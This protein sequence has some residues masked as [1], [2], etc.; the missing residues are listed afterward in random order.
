M[1]KNNCFGYPEVK[2]QLNW[3]PQATQWHATTIYF[4]FY[5]ADNG[6][7]EIKTCC[8]YIITIQNFTFESS[9][10]KMTVPTGIIPSNSKHM[11][12]T[13]TTLPGW[14]YIPNAQKNGEA[15][16]LFEKLIGRHTISIPSIL[17]SC[18]L[19]KKYIQATGYCFF[20]LLKTKIGL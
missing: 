5:R 14:L 7:C 15:C 18:Q 3:H 8:T 16:L 17:L 1:I 2:A 4:H 6:S 20:D 13:T 10:V 12:N 9:I 11:V 19:S